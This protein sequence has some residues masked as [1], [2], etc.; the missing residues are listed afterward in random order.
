MLKSTITLKNGVVVNV[1]TDSAEQ[2]MEILNGFGTN[3]AHTNVY[4]TTH[5]ERIVEKKVAEPQH[6]NKFNWTERDLVEIATVVTNLP[7]A[8]HKEVVNNLPKDIVSRHEE[9]SLRIMAGRIHRYL[10]GGKTTG[11][12]SKSTIRTLKKNGFVYKRQGAHKHPLVVWSDRDI[13]NI[14]KI[15]RSNID[16]KDSMAAIVKKY[17]VADGDHKARTDATIYTM[18]GDLRRYLSTGDERMIGKKFLR[19]LKDA[20]V[21]PVTKSATA[22]FLS[23]PRRITVQEA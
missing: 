14:A 15:V 1:E 13:V 21:T 8:T 5:S 22:S 2:F 12:I 6:S 7:R 18:S 19:V 4:A 9:T 17:I 16:T 23:E 20:G 11:G 3:V 10:I